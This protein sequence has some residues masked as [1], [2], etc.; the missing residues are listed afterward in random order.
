MISQ[1][2]KKFPDAERATIVCAC[3]T[4][5]IIVLLSAG[6]RVYV[7][8]LD[9]ALAR[10]VPVPLRVASVAAVGRRIVLVGSEGG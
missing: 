4:T 5:D 3:V 8:T 6:G 9:G 2:K 1:T 10:R 7:S